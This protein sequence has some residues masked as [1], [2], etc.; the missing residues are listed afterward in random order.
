MPTPSYVLNSLK[1]W[2]TI[3]VKSASDI[4][5]LVESGKITQAEANEII[6]AA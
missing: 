2:Y 3:G 6:N 4:N 5:A 1:F